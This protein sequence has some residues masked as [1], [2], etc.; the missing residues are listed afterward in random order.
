MSVIL[1]SQPGDKLVCVEAFSASPK[2]APFSWAT[3]RTFKIGERVRYVSHYRDE[4]HKDHP[5]GWM[6]VVLAADG[7]EYAATQTYFLTREA[8][9]NLEG[10]FLRKLLT[11]PF[12]LFLKPLRALRKR[13][14]RRESKQENSAQPPPRKG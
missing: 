10:H 2:G 8:W 9:G 13:L 7:K 4:H 12:Y 5:T 1:E 6:V 14:R 3:S 11:K